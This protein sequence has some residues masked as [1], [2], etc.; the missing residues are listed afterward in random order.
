MNELNGVAAN[1]AIQDHETNKQSTK[2]TTVS[3][4]SRWWGRERRN[5]TQ[6]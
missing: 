1:T 3:L 2:N 5:F 6:S 4:I